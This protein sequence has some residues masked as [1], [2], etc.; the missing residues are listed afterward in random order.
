MESQ[1]LKVQYFREQ[2]EKGIREIV[3]RQKAIVAERQLQF[4]SGGNDRNRGEAL[5]QA[6]GNP[7]YSLTQ[8]GNGMELIW[9]IPLQLR[10]VDM[11]HLGDWRVYNR[12][13]WPMMYGRVRSSIIYEYRDWLRKNLPRPESP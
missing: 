5:M 12:Q 6:V 8:R 9:R 10:F 4:G 11:K 1:G 2:L 7:Q 3:D 13:I